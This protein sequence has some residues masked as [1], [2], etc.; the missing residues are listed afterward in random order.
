MKVWL[1]R[2]L[3]LSAVGATLFTCHV[4]ARLYQYSTHSL[5]FGQG[6]EPASFC[7]LLLYAAHIETPCSLDA[8][9]NRLR[10]IDGAKQ[11]WAF[12]HRLNWTNDVSITWQD[13][14]PY[15]KHGPSGASGV[16]T[17]EGIQSESSAIRQHVL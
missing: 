17:G 12:E 7:Q 13:I 11:Q 16:R 10:Q 15:I 3:W 9:I 6:P 2:T 5:A 4:S 8:C 14:E 1:R